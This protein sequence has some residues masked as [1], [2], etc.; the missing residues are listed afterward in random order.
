VTERGVD[1]S[2]MDPSTTPGADFYAYANGAWMKS[3]VIPD[4]RSSTGPFMRIQEEVEKRLRTIL[5][6]CA[7]SDAP[8]GS[9]V[10]RIGDAYASFMDE[11]AI[12]AKGLTP[13]KPTFDRIAK[14]KDKRDLAALLGSNLRDDVDPLN[15]S[16]FWTERLF[17]FWAEQDLNDPSRVAAYLLQG[18]LG[19]PDRSYYLD[20]TP[21]MEALR[22]KYVA[23]ITRLMELAGIAQPAAKAV[24]CSTSSA[25]SPRRTPRGST[26]RT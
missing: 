22:T 3:A 8:P 24:R 16:V 19:M 12:E 14:V 10:R 18:G 1:M 9:P 6:E 25:P 21:P 17:G 7:A 26:P 13:L 11:P 20:A 23:F 2:A 15:N 4:D 5:E